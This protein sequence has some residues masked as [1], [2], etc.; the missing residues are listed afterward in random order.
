MAT[1][2]PRQTRQESSSA[3]ENEKQWAR[4]PIETRGQALSGGI[5][6]VVRTRRMNAVQVSGIA[7]KRSDVYTDFEGGTQIQRN[8][9]PFTTG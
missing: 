1:R 4:H 2:L 8:Q 3:N 7:N 6:N 9:R 5:K